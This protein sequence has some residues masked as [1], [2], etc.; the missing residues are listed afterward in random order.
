MQRA[1]STG[2]PSG[3]IV[4]ELHEGVVNPLYGHC[5]HHE[6]NVALIQLHLER[7]QPTVPKKLLYWNQD[8]SYS[9]KATLHLQCIDFAGYSIAQVVDMVL[10]AKSQGSNVSLGVSTEIPWAYDL[11]ELQ[12]LLIASLLASSRDLQ[13]EINYARASNV[14]GAVDDVIASIEVLYCELRMPEESFQYDIA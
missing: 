9:P 14:V 12:F 10:F 2:P 6:Q 8:F 3:Y 13:D 7:I 11:S 4:S 5:P 1:V